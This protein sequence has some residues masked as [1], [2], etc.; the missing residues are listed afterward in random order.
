MF[1]LTTAVSFKIY[2]FEK[3]VALMKVNLNISTY[4]CNNG[5]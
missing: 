2:Y 3:G 1:I 5:T 4:N